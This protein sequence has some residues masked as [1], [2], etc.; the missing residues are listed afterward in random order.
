[1]LRQMSVDD[2]SGFLLFVESQWMIIEVRMQVTVT[3]IMLH[4]VVTMHDRP[5]LHF[6]YPPKHERVDIMLYIYIYVL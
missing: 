6:Q 3:T 5:F 2:Q 1:M 4:M